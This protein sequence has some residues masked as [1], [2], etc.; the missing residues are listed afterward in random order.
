MFQRLKDDFLLRKLNPIVNIQLFRVQYLHKRLVKLI[1]GGKAMGI[2][3]W[4]QIWSYLKSVNYKLGPISIFVCKI[5]RPVRPTNA[6]QDRAL[7]KII[8]LRHLAF[9]I[10]AHV[11]NAIKIVLLFSL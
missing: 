9:H 6:S 11:F 1:K 3:F 8:F 4:C 10:G 7:T 2:T 5:M